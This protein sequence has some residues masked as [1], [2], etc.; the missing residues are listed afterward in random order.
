MPEWA[1]F[2]G[3]IEMSSYWYYHE[4]DNEAGKCKVCGKTSAEIGP[5]PDA[6]M[7]LPGKKWR[8]GS[9]RCRPIADHPVTQPVKEPVVE[10]GP[11]DEPDKPK[12]KRFFI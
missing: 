7:H 4:W 1:G 8:I 5:A 3:G 12:R 2:E 11:E 10:E 6:Q 9:V